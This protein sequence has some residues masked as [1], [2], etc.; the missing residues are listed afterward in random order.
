M[1]F[2]D[3][4]NMRKQL[5][6]RVFAYAGVL[7]ILLLIIAS[8]LSVLSLL[9][10]AASRLLSQRRHAAAVSKVVCFTKEAISCLLL[11]ATILYPA[12]I[13]RQLRSSGSTLGPAYIV[14]AFIAAL[15]YFGP[16]VMKGCVA[17]RKRLCHKQNV[18][19]SSQVPT[20][21]EQDENM[22]I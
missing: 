16:T 4:D 1:F 15:I 8:A 19:T 10:L 11:A 3:D 6:V 14:M 9:A 17:T 7:V 18:I 22:I 5:Q 13:F 21:D 20:E 12:T 2:G